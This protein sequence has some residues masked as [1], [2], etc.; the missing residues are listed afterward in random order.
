MEEVALD[1]SSMLYY[2]MC[3]HRSYFDHQCIYNI[4]QS[5]NKSFVYYVL[6]KSSEIYLYSHATKQLI[7]QMHQ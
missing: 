7:K 2:S 3:L 5:T 6:K 1:Y 4:F